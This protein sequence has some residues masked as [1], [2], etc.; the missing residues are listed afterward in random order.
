MSLRKMKNENHNFAVIAKTLFL[1]DTNV[2]MK[3]RITRSFLH[4]FMLIKVYK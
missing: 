1:T 4:F 2:E 3:Q